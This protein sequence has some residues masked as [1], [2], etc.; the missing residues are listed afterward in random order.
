MKLALLGIALGTLAGFVCVTAML[1]A[2]PHA[3]RPLECDDDCLRD[4]ELFAAYH[5]RRG[6]QMDSLARAMD[7]NGTRFAAGLQ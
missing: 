4:V 7:G 5:A 3:H 1:D 6:M 2:K